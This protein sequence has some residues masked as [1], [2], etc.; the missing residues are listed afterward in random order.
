MDRLA[1]NVAFV[2]NL[3]ESGVEF[4]AVD[5]PQANR[6]TVHILAAV[7]EHEAKAKSDRTK[8]ALGAAKAGALA[9]SALFSNCLANSGQLMRHLLICGNDFVEGVGDLTAQSDPRPWK[10]NREI[11]LLHA[12]KAGEDHTQFGFVWLF[13]CLDLSVSIP[14]D[15]LGNG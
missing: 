14:R 1:R 4:V 11:S 9:D 3:M 8:A 7:A 15:G 10:A 6:L 5:F 13:R 12:L 2:S